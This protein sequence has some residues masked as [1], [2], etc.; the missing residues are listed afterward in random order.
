LKEARTKS[1]PAVIEILIVQCEGGEDGKKAMRKQYS[2][3]NKQEIVELVVQMWL[4]NAS[5][6]CDAP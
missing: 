2:K 5:V 1:K 4:Q 3:N 6:A